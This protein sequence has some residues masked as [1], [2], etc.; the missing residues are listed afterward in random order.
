MGQ[1]SKRAKS[2]LYMQQQQALFRCPICADAL[3]VSDEGKMFC[4]SNH[5]FDIAKQGY[6]NLMH[7]PATTM[8]SKELFEAR[9]QI[10]ASGLYDE[11]QQAI[12]ALISMPAP[13]ILDTGCGEGSHLAR[14]CHH[15]QDAVGVGIDI[16]KEGIIAAA[17]FYDD[18]IWC[19]GDLAN[20]PYNEATFDV[21]LNILSPANYDEF[22][23]L[24]KPGGKVIKIVPQEGYLKE[25]RAQAFADSEKESYSNAQTVNRFKASFANVQVE[26]ITYTKPLAAHLVPKLLE[27]TPMGWHIEHREDIQLHEITI[28]LNILVGECE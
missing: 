4:A 8:Y 2:I 13:V 17:K 10:I 21:I 18:N 1:L 15:L 6:I 27:M 19:V 26:R 16:A 25:L 22:K 20:S 12:A 28:D 14:I 7:R 23:R 5:S 3:Q 11:L 24:L 9:Q